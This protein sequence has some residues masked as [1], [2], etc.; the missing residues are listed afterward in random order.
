M[1]SDGT[2]D[3]YGMGPVSV[4]PEFQ[5]QGI[6]RSLVNEGLSILKRMGAKG[7][8]LVSPLDYYVRFGFNNIPT[9]IHEGIPQEVFPV[10]PFTE[11]VPE[12]I[13]TFHEV[14]SAQS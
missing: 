12:G 3:W 4:L 10:L 1:I 8:A 11:E 13:V 14:F 2:D 9:L 7:C 6:G 5:K